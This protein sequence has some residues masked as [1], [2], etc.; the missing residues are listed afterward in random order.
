MVKVIINA[1]D[2]GIRESTSLR[3][4][5]AISEKKISS[6][7]ILANGVAHDIVKECVRRYPDV[8]YGVHLNLT[9]GASLLKD[10]KL[11]EIGILNEEG[12]FTGKIR[13]LKNLSETAKIAIKTEL[14]A[15]IEAVK[16]LGITISHFDGHHHVHSLPIVKPIVLELLKDNGIRRVR[17]DSQVVLHQFVKDFFSTPGYALKE[18]RVR[19]LFFNNFSTTDY[20]YSIDKFYEYLTK[21]GQIKDNSIIEL[22]CHLGDH[23]VHERELVE[24]NTL[25]ELLQYQLISYL[26]I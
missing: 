4:V 22:M 16:N 5:Q 25:R 1:D 20:F 11:Y 19:N 26:D 18:Y 23:H 17:L 8:S 21:R 6:T 12:D 13:S 3:I 24:N 14:A 15:Q 10:S 2:F 7:T 9:T